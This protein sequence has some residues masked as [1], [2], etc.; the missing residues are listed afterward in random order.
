MVQRAHIGV[1]TNQYPQTILSRESY[2]KLEVGLYKRPTDCR[3]SVTSRVVPHS[4][5]GWTYELVLD[6]E[7]RLRDNYNTARDPRMFRNGWH[8][9]RR[10]DRRRGS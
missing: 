7:I 2:D 10:Q 8:W 6:G 1:T 4:L 3:L 9:Q 5:G